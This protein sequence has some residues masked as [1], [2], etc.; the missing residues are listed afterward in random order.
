MVTVNRHGHARHAAHRS[1][2][3]TRLG[4]QRL[5]PSLASTHQVIRRIPAVVRSLVQS[6]RARRWV[7]PDIHPR[8]AP[9]PAQSGVYG[10]RRL[11]KFSGRPSPAAAA[12][13]IQV[14]AAAGR[15]GSVSV[16]PERCVWGQTPEEIFWPAFPRGC[17]RENTGV[18]CSRPRRIG[19]RLPGAASAA[20]RSSPDD[21]AGAA[22]QL[23]VCYNHPGRCA[24]SRP[25]R[26]RAAL[27]F[28]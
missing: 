26:P 6:G 19:L 25:E 20:S 5:S 3:I 7:F 21:T 18:C 27:G 15:A 13:K 8:R 14:Y 24:E 23:A 12:G 11:K 10:D 28:P 1:S 22:H 2:H 16:S 9:F 4:A 17:R